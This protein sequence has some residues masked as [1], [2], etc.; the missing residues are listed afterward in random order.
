MDKHPLL[1]GP[2]WSA[3][4][5][6]NAGSGSSFDKDRPEESNMPWMLIRA[7]LRLCVVCSWANLRRKHTGRDEPHDIKL[8]GLGNES[9]SV[10]FEAG[11]IDL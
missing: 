3:G 1:S 2:G 10:P 4:S 9:E 11:D 8:W 6:E 5:G 7:A